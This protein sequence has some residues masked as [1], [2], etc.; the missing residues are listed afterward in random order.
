MIFVS[1][2]GL[3]E[4][5]CKELPGLNKAIE[6]MMIAGGAFGGE[7]VVFGHEGNALFKKVG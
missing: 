6:W 2:D 3:V 7:I 5:V 4:F 1:I